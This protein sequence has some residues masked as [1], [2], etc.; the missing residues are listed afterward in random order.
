MLDPTW[1]DS[2]VEAG[3]HQGLDSAMSGLWDSAMNVARPN[4]NDLSADNPLVIEPNH[5][6]LSVISVDAVT[7][8]QLSDAAILTILGSAPDANSF[9]PPYSGTDKTI[10][11]NV[12][13]LDYSSLSTLTPVASAPSLATA[14][15][16]FE[17]PWLSFHSY[18][19]SIHP[20][21]NMP[22]RNDL[23]AERI[24]EGALVLNL[25]YTNAQKKTLMIRF[26]QVGIDLYGILANDGRRIWW[27]NGAQ[28]QGRKM[29]ILFVGTTL[30]DSNMT[31]AIGSKS[32]DYLYS[33]DY[34]PENE[35]PDYLHFAEDDQIFYVDGNDVF[36]PPYVLR[37]AYVGYNP[38]QKLGA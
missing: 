3:S 9:R 27:A 23:F 38:P 12:S 31:T 20:T 5:S 19:D 33:G 34:G 24:G 2:Y 6:L 17:R 29:P 4:G 13:D 21:N 11:Y 15:G 35:P 1:Q 10:K 14:E 26:V 37:G 25:N 18:L 32:G 7:R 36:I 30:N 16:W 22:G 8:Y 28:S